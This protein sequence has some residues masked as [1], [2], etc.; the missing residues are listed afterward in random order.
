MFIT[1]T[2]STF[3]H[4]GVFSSYFCTVRE[5]ECTA[6]AVNIWKSNITRVYF[7]MRYTWINIS[8]VWST[9]IMYPVHMAYSAGFTHI[10]KYFL[11]GVHVC[12]S[13]GFCTHILIF[14]G[15]ST[16]CTVLR[17]S[18]PRILHTRR[19]QTHCEKMS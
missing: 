13:L 10:D 16:G 6:R 17:R 12:Y 14:P 15:C 3:A 2:E 11:Y 19:L 4:I 1:S 18:F 8:S 7:C 9:W 5:N